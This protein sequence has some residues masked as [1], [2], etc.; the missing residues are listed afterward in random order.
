[1]LGG[2]NAWIYYDPMLAGN[3]YL[4]DQFFTLNGVTIAP[5]TGPVPEPGTYAMLLAGLGLLGMMVRR[6]KTG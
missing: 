1:V 6:R 5:V 4:K 2:G 3:A